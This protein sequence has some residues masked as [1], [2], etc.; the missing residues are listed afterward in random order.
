LQ[1]R[2]AGDV[3]LIEKPFTQQMLA[4]KVGEVLGSQAEGQ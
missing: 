4:R 2:F 3:A 1:E